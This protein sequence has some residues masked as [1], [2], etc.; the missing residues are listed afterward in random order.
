MAGRTYRFTGGTEGNSY[1]GIRAVAY[2]SGNPNDPNGAAAYFGNYSAAVAIA[3]NTGVPS[4]AAFLVGGQETTRMP[5]QIADYEGVWSINDVDNNNV[6]G[7]FGAR[8]D[9]NARRLAFDLRDPQGRNRYGS[10]AAVIGSDSRGIR[11][12]G[13]L[14]TNA[15]SMPGTYETE[16]YFYGPNANEIA[17]VIAAERPTGTDAAGF[18]I[19][20]RR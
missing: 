11:F 19:G 1:G 15:T 7:L 6:N 20:G 18:L 9:F 17:G 14:E 5:S 10:G 3:D 12:D 16:G 4:R 8:A 13:E 2:D